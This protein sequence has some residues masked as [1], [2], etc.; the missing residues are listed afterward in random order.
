MCTAIRIYIMM[1]PNHDETHRT[2]QDHP[3]LGCRELVDAICHRCDRTTLLSLSVSCLA[4]SDSALNALWYNIPSIVPLIRCMPDD[5][6]EEFETASY[7]SNDLPLRVLVTMSWG[8]RLTKPNDSI[9][10]IS[11]DQFFPPI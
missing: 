4:I 7:D 3:V 8:Y 1:D 6:W 9:S 10:S 11:A 5:L 2:L